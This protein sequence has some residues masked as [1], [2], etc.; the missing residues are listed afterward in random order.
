MRRKISTILF[1]LTLLCARIAGADEKWVPDQ[2]VTV[3]GVKLNYLDYGGTGEVMVM[4]DEFADND[5]SPRIFDKLGP[6]FTDH[7]HVVALGRR[8]CDR[9]DKPASGYDTSTRVEDL[10]QFLGALH[11]DRAVFMGIGNA[12]EEM[13]L[14]ATLYPEQVNK[15]IYLQ[16]FDDRGRHPEVMV[17]DPNNAPWQKELL[18]EVLGKFGDGW[19]KLKIRPDREQWEMMKTACKAAH[20]F[21]ADY[22]GVLAPALAIF[23]N[24]EKDAAHTAFEMARTDKGRRWARWIIENQTPLQRA[25]IEEFRHR[26]PHGQVVELDSGSIDAVNDDWPGVVSNTR[27]FLLGEPLLPKGVAPYDYP[28]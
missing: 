15:L 11:I 23:P 2:F 3:N 25:D 22:A 16:P 17:K 14:L 19:K 10:H 21:H 8:G 27:H 18:E 4:L 9:A 7:F 13:T 28:E 6:L 1:C 24:P 5:S 26:M 12:G 20:A